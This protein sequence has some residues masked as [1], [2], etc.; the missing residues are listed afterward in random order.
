MQHIINKLPLYISQKRLKH[1]I[2]VSKKAI[3]LAQLYKQNEEKATI[4]A[5]IH[6]SA[7]EFSP[8][9]CRQNSIKLSNF[10]EE[11]YQSYQSIWHALIVDQFASIVFGIKDP[12]VLGAA[13]WHT[14]GHPEMSELAKIIFVADYIDPLRGYKDQIEIEELAKKSLDDAILIIL[15]KTIRLLL[16]KHATIY[17]ATIACYNKALIKTTLDKKNIDE[18]T[19]L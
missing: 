2:S 4:A 5:L 9:K 13:K 12:E 17:E 16:V 19:K 18:L 1:T 7:K 14:T 8:A 10:Q 3:E 15:I 6:D 11:I